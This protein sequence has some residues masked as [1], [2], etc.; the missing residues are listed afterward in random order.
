MAEELYR[1]YK[2]PIRQHDK[3]ISLVKTVDV[4][5]YFGKIDLLTFSIFYQHKPSFNILLNRGVNVNPNNYRDI[6]PLLWCLKLLIL[7]I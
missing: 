1:L 7:I 4:N 5:E 3:I 2:Q 6:P